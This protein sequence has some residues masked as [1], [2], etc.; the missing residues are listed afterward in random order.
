VIDTARL[1]GMSKVEAISLVKSLGYSPRVAKENGK[2]Y[3]PPLDYIPKVVNL[4][5][6]DSIVTKAELEDME[7]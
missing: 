4:T 2:I 7:Y 1:V 3:D 5:I 6:R